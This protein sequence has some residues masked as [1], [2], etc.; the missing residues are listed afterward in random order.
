MG[1]FQGCTPG[2]WKQ[3][4]HIDSWVGFLPTQNYDEVF[5]VDFFTPDRTLLVALSTG[6]GGLDALGRHSV[7]ALLNASNPDVNYPLSV[8]EIIDLV[9][10]IEPE[11]DPEEIENLKDLFQ[12][13]N[14]A[15]C[16]LS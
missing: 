13:F 10:A 7:A 9:Q 5:G 12:D 2:F 15:F 1:L 4:Q 8:A 3:P 14:E 6:G 11:E 16:P